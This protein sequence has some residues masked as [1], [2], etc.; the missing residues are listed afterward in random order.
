MSFLDKFVNNT[1]DEKNANPLKNKQPY[2]YDINDEDKEI[3]Q[4]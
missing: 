4:L 3:D 2:G 1:R